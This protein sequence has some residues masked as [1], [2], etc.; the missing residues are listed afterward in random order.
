MAGKEEVL[1]SDS[2]TAGRLLPYDPDVVPVQRCLWTAVI[3]AQEQ[4]SLAPYLGPGEQYAY[5]SMPA[6]AAV[7]LDN[8]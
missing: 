5:G 1:A 4:P 6:A 2:Y 8:S 3:R 7:C